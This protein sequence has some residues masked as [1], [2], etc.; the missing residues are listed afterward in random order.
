MNKLLKIFSV[1]LIMATMFSCED[2]ENNSGWAKI[3][4][5]FTVARVYDAAAGTT[6]FDFTGLGL[7]D[8]SLFG[9]YANYS[10]DIA[11]IG[12][13]LLFTKVWFNEDYADGVDWFINNDA[14]ITG[15][16]RFNVTTNIYKQTFKH[17]DSPEIDFDVDNS[18]TKTIISITDL[19]NNIEYDLEGDHNGNGVMT[20]VHIDEA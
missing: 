14:S 13:T 1:A 18:A 20:V 17:A 10:T 12:T 15:F 5:T 11:D 2:A 3:G 16:E 8:S 7:D 6:T 19:V 4:D 9:I